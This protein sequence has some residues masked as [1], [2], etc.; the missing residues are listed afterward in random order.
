MRSVPNQ[1][2]SPIIAG[3]VSVGLKT[4][5]VEHA[6]STGQ[7]VTDVLVTAL[8]RYRKSAERTARSGK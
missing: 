1:P 5:V 2:K 3:R 7:T 6:E 8:E 4:W